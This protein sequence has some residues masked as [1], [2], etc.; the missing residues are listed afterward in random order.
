MNLFKW[1]LY[2]LQLPVSLLREI[3]FVVVAKACLLLLKTL[4]VLHNHFIF[5]ICRIL[6]DLN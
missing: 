2:V 5:M 6:A 3:I 4:I 1:L